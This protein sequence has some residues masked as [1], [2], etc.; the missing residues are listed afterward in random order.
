MENLFETN[1]QYEL[2]KKLPLSKTDKMLF[3]KYL[4]EIESCKTD[5]EKKELTQKRIEQLKKLPESKTNI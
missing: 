2:F 4:L 1:D 5:E 3:L